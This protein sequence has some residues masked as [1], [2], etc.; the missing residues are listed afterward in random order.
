MRGAAEC[1]E[2]EAA[3]AGRGRKQ[4]RNS[5]SRLAEVPGCRRPLPE[6]PAST[7]PPA[8]H[9]PAPGGP[10]SLQP[11]H[12]LTTASASLQPQHKDNITDF[13]EEIRHGLIAS[14]N[15]LNCDG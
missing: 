12:S 15:K 7:G 9:G 2:P 13:S 10:A 4:D 8:G 6:L 3:A 11:H 1:S 5:S 14:T